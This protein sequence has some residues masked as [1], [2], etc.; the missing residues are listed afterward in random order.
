[1]RR[2]GI[3]FLLFGKR[4]LKRPVYLVILLLMPL[5]AAGLS[6]AQETSPT[7][8]RAM[9]YTQETETDGTKRDAAL[10]RIVGALLEADG[11]VQF[12]LASSEEAMKQSILKKEADCGYTFPKDF[13]TRLAT[14]EWK[15][16]VTLYCGE[17]T[18]IPK[19]VNELV[20]TAVFREYSAAAFGDYMSTAY[21]IPAGSRQNAQN[22]AEDLLKLYLTNGS[23]FSFTYY[24][25]PLGSGRTA[26]AETETALD[27]T[28]GIV[29]VRGMLALFIMLSAFCGLID[30]KK[31][32]EAGRLVWMR[33][34]LAAECMM[35]ILP[36]L[37]AAAVS[38][39]CL[40][41]TG[42][43]SGAL[44]EITS[45]I[46][47]ILLLTGYV[48]VWGLLFRSEHAV[49]ASIPFLVIAAILFC[50]IFWNLK[51][52]LPILGMM[53]K[54]FPASWYLNMIP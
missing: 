50:P 6:A 41:V 8:I 17:D 16:S 9:L 19:L 51:S 34:K 12:E 43:A 28:S 18:M 27:I 20:Y 54:L 13:G 14:D 33:S 47:Y 10:W 42:E 21:E 32:R 31:D 45:V 48:I 7:G 44:S 22:R 1:M 49:V 37:G 35:I 5:A 39:I 52:V 26:A 25:E 29:P 46:I 3:H 36:A 4:L 15:R 30:Y 24:G 38:L 11:A 23:T 53:E 2:M 40:A